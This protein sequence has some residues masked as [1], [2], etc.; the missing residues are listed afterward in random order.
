M[1]T[2]ID[3]IKLG[4]SEYE[5]DLKSTATPSIASLTT[6]ALT[7]NGNS[8]LDTVTAASINVGELELGID[9]IRGPGV[10][11]PISAESGDINLTATLGNININRTYTNSSSTPGT[12][13]ISNQKGDITLSTYEGNININRN[14]IGGPSPTA[15]A[16][17]ISNAKGDITLNTLEGNI[18]IDATTSTSDSG[19]K[20]TLGPATVNQGTIYPTISLKGYVTM[21]GPHG[22]A[23]VSNG[24]IKT[25][26]LTVSV[27]ISTPKIEYPGNTSNNTLGIKLTSTNITL[28]SGKATDASISVISPHG[29]IYLQTNDG[30]IGLS[31]SGT[32]ASNTLTISKHDTYGVSVS[33]GQGLY[34][35][36]SKTSESGGLTLDLRVNSGSPFYLKPK[37]V[38]YVTGTWLVLGVND[39]AVP[40]IV[41]NASGKES[42]AYLQNI[43]EI[44]STLVG[45]VLKIF[46]RSAT[47]N[48]QSLLVSMPYTNAS[49]YC[50]IRNAHLIRLT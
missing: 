40:Q 6:S 44:K 31:T 30:K 19:G 45:N 17:T 27:G 38:D 12:I 18:N 26:A 25:T 7:V 2:K 14:Y 10:D 49:Y 33:A 50:Y 11:V 24:Y 42:S 46:L 41:S 43:C 20:I 34:V 3:T 9:G 22:S 37:D 13:K 1:A 15:G 4:T 16:I 8:D 47:T 48:T 32:S 21:V 29:S 28:S 35:T 36:A 5:I 39:D 23:T